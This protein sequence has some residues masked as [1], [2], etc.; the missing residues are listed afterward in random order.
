MC[1]SPKALKPWQHAQSSQR[2]G[3]AGSKSAPFLWNKSLSTANKFLMLPTFIR[4][5]V[6]ARNVFAPK[7]NS[8]SRRKYSIISVHTSFPASLYRFQPRRNSGLFDY[9]QDSDD[10]EDGLKVS[11]DGLVY[12]RVSKDVPCRCCL[13]FCRRPT[14][15]VSQ[16]PTAQSLCPIHLRCKNGFAQPLTIMSMDLR[17]P[18]NIRCYYPSGRKRYIVS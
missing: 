3:V 17:W 14:S 15:D 6:C 8:S 18:V 7:S 1:D 10:I 13:L 2:A 16:S 4:H 11:A 9:K 5:F 12:P